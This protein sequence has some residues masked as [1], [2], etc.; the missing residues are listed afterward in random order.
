MCKPRNDAGLDQVCPFQPGS[1]MRLRGPALSGLEG[2]VQKVSVKRVVL[3][4]EI[5]GHAKTLK[6]DFDQIEAV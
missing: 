3:L 4:L 2:L 6:V 1:H 5:L